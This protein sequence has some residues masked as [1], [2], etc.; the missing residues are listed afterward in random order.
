[1]RDY[2]FPQIFR[3]QVLVP[4][5]PAPPPPMPKT[6]RPPSTPFDLSAK[7]LGDLATLFERESRQQAP[8]QEQA[9]L[10]AIARE[11]DRLWRV[12]TASTRRRHG[13]RR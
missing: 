3:P 2:A 12:K 6:P 5:R 7:L 10:F 8:V 11:L 13:G 9:R 4:T 1:M